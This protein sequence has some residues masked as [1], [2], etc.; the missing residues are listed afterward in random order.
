M[1]ELSG[2]KRERKVFPSFDIN[3]MT[4]TFFFSFF[5]FPMSIE[6][7]QKSIKLW[8]IWIQKIIKWNKEIAIEPR[9][10]RKNLFDNDFL[11]AVGVKWE[12]PFDS[13]HQLRIE[14]ETPPPE[15]FANMKQNLLNFVSFLESISEYFLFRQMLIEFWIRILFLPT[16]VIDNRKKSEK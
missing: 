14:N 12:N 4:E 1:N 10:M 16:C 6:N 11:V 3:Q 8:N 13:H 15:Y 7:K 9:K 2:R 5:P